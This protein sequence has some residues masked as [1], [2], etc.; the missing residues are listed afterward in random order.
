MRALVS[1][2]CLFT[3][4]AFGQLVTLT[5]SDRGLR[6][7]VDGQLFTEYVTVTAHHP[8]FFPLIGPGGEGITRVYPLPAGAEDDHPHHASL[9]MG[10]GSVNGTDFWLEGSDRG[11]VKHTAFSDVKAEGATASFVAKSSWVTPDGDEVMTDERLYT[12]TALAEGGRQIDCVVSFIAGQNEV[13]FGD[14]KEGTFAFRACKSLSVEGEGAAG[15][16][17]NS[18]GKTDKKVWGKTAKWISYYGPDPKGTEVSISFLDHPQNLRHPTPWHARTYG[19]LGAN[20]FG[21][22]DFQKSEDKAL[23]EHKLAPGTKLT[24]RYRI[25]M[26]KGAPVKEQLDAAWAQFAAK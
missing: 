16:I 5:S 8:H 23:G 26:A 15:H 4:S 6:V 3:A 22:H 21:L 12:I 17:L 11:V 25:L 14:T 2:L 20:P 10:H 7:D 9:W 13:T 18:E 19:L 1:L 24:Q